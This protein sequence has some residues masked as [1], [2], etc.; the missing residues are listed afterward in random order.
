LAGTS[1]RGAQLEGHAHGEQITAAIT[2][3]DGADE[4]PVEFEMTAPIRGLE[5]GR[6][7]RTRRLPLDNTPLIRF[8]RGKVS[9]RYGDVRRLGVASTPL[10][11]RR[12][13]R[14]RLL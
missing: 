6:G 1:F 7:L 10:K 3:P 12:L 2:A 8:C 5:P 4:E 14:A 9:A 13:A 11:Q